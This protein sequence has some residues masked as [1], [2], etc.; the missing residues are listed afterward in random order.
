[1]IKKAVTDNIFI[2]FLTLMIS[3]RQTNN[4]MHS[5]RAL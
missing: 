3:R 2:L 1:M 5:K 4:N